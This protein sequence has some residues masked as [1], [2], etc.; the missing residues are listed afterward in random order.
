MPFSLVVMLTLVSFPAI[1]QAPAQPDSNLPLGLLIVTIPAARAEKLSIRIDGD[2]SFSSIP[3]Y[4]KNTGKA[5]LT[6]L[7]FYVQLTDAAGA[8]VPLPAVTLQIKGVSSSDRGVTL[9]PGKEAYATL[10][11]TQFN[12]VG[13]R[14]G[15]L[16]AEGN[17][18]TTRLAVAALERYPIARIRLVG[19]AEGAG[20]NLTSKATGFRHKFWIESINRGSVKS[21]QVL[22]APLNGPDAVQVETTWTLGRPGGVARAG[23]ARGPARSSWR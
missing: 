12:D 19:A 14:T 2:A 3:L 20:I 1:G 21:L 22:V 4:V 7:R 16:L 10:E 23:A 13:T 5:D 15:W 6:S 8:I 11:V 18:T 9:P 17:G